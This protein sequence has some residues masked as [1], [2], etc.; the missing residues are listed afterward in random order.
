ML[1]LLL[2]LLLLGAVTSAML[3]ELD[4]SLGRV[5][6]A[7]HERQMLNNSIVVFSTDNGGAAANFQKGAG[8]NQPLRCEPG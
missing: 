7:L 2:L 1:A 8:C 5:V 3:T 6:K 4:E